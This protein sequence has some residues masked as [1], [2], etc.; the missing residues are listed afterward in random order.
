[1]KG[2]ADEQSPKPAVPDPK[3]QEIERLRR[4]LERLRR[5][6][7]RLKHELDLARRAAKRQAA[8]AAGV[9]RVVLPFVDNSEI[10]TAAEQDELVEMLEHVIPCADRCQIELHLEMSLPPRMF[11]SFLDRVPLDAVK[12]TYD[13]GNSASLGYHPADEF[14]AYGDRIGSVHVKDR[15]LGG[16]TVPLGTDDADLPALFDCLNASAY[17]G[18]L[19]LRRS[20][21]TSPN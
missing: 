9:T 12:V 11:S 8:R 16:T 17:G 21:A 7:K 3:D 20:I 10:R 5:E 19:V 14:A 6:N 15:V 2:R 18:D 4:E 13:S 1:M